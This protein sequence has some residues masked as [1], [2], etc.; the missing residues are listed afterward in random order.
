MS[1]SPHERDA[2]PQATRTRRSTNSSSVI[3]KLLS[4]NSRNIS[5][6]LPSRMPEQNKSDINIQSGERDSQRVQT[7]DTVDVER[8]AMAADKNSRRHLYREESVIH[9]LGIMGNFNGNLG[10]VRSKNIGQ[11]ELSGDPLPSNEISL[12][13]VEVDGQGSSSTEEDELS[14]L[15]D[16][17]LNGMNGSQIKTNKETPN[18][19]QE[20]CL[21]DELSKSDAVKIRLKVLDNQHY[22]FNIQGP[23]GLFDILEKIYHYSGMD[24]VKSLDVENEF[25]KVEDSQNRREHREDKFH[26]GY[27]LIPNERQLLTHENEGDVYEAAS[28]NLNYARIQNSNQ[29]I[30][31]VDPTSD[32]EKEPSAEGRSQDVSSAEFSDGI[33]AISQLGLPHSV[34]NIAS[35]SP[36]AVV[37]IPNF[38]TAGSTTELTPDQGV[39]AFHIDKIAEDEMKSQENYEVVTLTESG[40][41]LENT[42]WNPVNRS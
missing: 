32:L 19:S 3:L 22:E 42:T 36:A 6:S 27:F 8:E 10:R 9:Q 2:Q 13:D 20:D 21:L 38:Q 41:P 39:E 31:N 24:D 30:H 15:V 16:N 7:I 5:I 28:S 18:S 14:P 34:R 37:N 35:A 26:S 17:K 1:S 23:G 12:T 29:N 25:S 4:Q 33:K 11:K 40:L